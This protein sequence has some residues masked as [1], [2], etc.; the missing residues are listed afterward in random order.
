M[1]A[2]NGLP[3]LLANLPGVGTLIAKGINLYMLRRLGLLAWPNIWA[4]RQIVPEL[5][6]RLEAQSVA[7]QM[8]DYLEHPEKLEAMRQEM[9][10]VSG[11]P[12]ASDRLVEL[13]VDVLG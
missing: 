12:G 7:D 9:R 10:S 2:W 4:G 6:G 8:L 13:V 1:R 3:G 5:V 11:Q